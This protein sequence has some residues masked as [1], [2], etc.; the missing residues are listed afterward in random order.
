MLKALNKAKVILVVLML[1]I[2]MVI[3]IPHKDAQT[4]IS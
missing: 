3:F 1:F 4:A 2:L